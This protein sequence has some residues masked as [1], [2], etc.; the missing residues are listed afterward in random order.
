VNEDGK[1]RVYWQNDTNRKQ[2][3]GPY[4]HVI[5][6]ST[7]S[8][9]FA[10][11][12]KDGNFDPNRGKP[13][14]QSFTSF[15]KFFDEDKTYELGPNTTAKNLYEFTDSGLAEATIYSYRIKACSFILV[16]LTKDK[17]D[18]PNTLVCGKYTPTVEKNTTR[19]AKPLNLTATVTSPSAIELS[20]IDDSNGENG[21]VIYRNNIFLKSV[22][23]A[24]GRGTTVSASDSGLSSGAT[25]TYKVTAYKFNPNYPNDF[26]KRAESADSNQAEIITMVTL[27]VSKSGPG[28]GTI[29]STDATINCGSICSAD[30]EYGFSVILNAATTTIIASST[31]EGWGGACVSFGTSSTCALTMDSDKNVTATFGVEKEKLLAIV[32]S[33]INS[34]E[35]LLGG[36]KSFFNKVWHGFLGIVKEFFRPETLAQISSQ[37]SDE[38]LNNYFSQ[39]V[40]DGKD[41]NLSGNERRM[42]G[43]STYED[44]GLEPNTVYLYRVKAVYTDGTESEYSEL[45]AGKTLPAD[46]VLK[47]NEF[48]S[49]CT[50]NSFCQHRFPKYSS[51]TAI[52]TSVLTIESEHQCDNNAEC[53]DVGTSR[54]FFE[55]TR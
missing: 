25:Y 22:G 30:Y 2:Y 46:A 11:R 36:F 50:R 12:D 37:I 16:D 1:L 54:Q 24:A 15:N 17:V 38:K 6:R 35:S 9:P 29:S 19:P 21:F 44:K 43:L 34:V 39:F 26:N 20:W 31:F 51:S 8:E 32:A 41:L 3:K 52:G 53:R 55:E 4:Y 27:S 5:E 48:V 14:D 49:I 33:F 45:R 40:K 7:S 47:Q 10:D 42:I 28:S 13:L 18:N 23:F